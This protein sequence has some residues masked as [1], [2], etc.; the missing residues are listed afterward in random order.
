MTKSDEEKLNIQIG[1][2]LPKD[3]EHFIRLAAAAEGMN[4]LTW[5]RLAIDEKLKTMNICQNCRNINR[6]HAKFCEECGEPLN[7]KVKL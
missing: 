5:I 1:L 7:P 6:Q 2:R 3:L 4:K